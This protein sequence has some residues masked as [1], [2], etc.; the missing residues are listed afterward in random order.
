MAP[1]SDQ[2]TK[3]NLKLP[4]YHFRRTSCLPPSHAHRHCL[5]RLKHNLSYIREPRHARAKTYIRK[6]LEIYANPNPQIP[7]VFVPA[8]LFSAGM[9]ALLYDENQN[10]DEIAVSSSERIGGLFL[11]M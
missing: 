4:L 9:T 8:T 3:G 10:A 1:F 5:A 6:L 11:A 2:S 7:V